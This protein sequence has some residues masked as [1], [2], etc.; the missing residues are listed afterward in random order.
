MNNEP[1]STPAAEADTQAES[2]A[3]K[4]AKWM[5][6]IVE[7]FC[8]A[9]I[10]VVLIFAFF[11]RTC[12]VDGRSMNNTLAHGEIILISD[13]MYEP[14]AGDIV[15]FHLVN[16]YYA[17]PLV[18][19]VIATE[20]QY[21]KIDL[22]EKQVYVNGAPI[23]DSHAYLE[24]DVY[25]PG[26]FDYNIEKDQNGHDVYTATVPEGKIFVMGDN[27]NHSTDSRSFMV[28]LIDVDCVLGKA[29]CRLSPFSSLN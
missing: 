11:L 24:N 22:T 19:R 7:I 5:Y 14:E 12:R 20:G 16:D 8:I 15:V 1:H 10:A 17:E 4:A 28:G 29:L 6:D 2:G 25:N 27:R 21:V 23:N 26:Y 3:F 13:F 18:K 9:V